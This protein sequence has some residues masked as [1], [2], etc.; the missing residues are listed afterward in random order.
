[1]ETFRRVALRSNGTTNANTISQ[2]ALPVLAEE[3]RWAN[4]KRD[5]AG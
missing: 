3:Y 4:T 5:A 1:M 2:N